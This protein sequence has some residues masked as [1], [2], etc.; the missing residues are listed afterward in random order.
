M[1][2]KNFVLVAFIAVLIGCATPY[3]NS[4]GA[5][6]GGWNVKP[7]EGDI[8][9]V[10]FY[11]NGY[12]TE[13]TVQTFWLYRCA[14]L[15]LEK[16]YDGFEIL[17]H[18]SLTQHIPV[19][20]LFK[21]KPIFRKAQ[22]Y[23]IPMDSGPKPQITADI[24]LLK[25]P[26]NGHPPKVFDAAKLEDAIDEFMAV[27]NCSMGNVCAHVHKYLHPEGKFDNI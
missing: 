25:A 6:S 17:S 10:S 19:D 23:Y 24:K 15:A 3:Q 9:R 4:S 22:V 8:Y 5:L 2:V 27:E 1:K 18:I 14:E 13:E 12:T 16:G 21:E 26:L 7:L 20:Q 11:G